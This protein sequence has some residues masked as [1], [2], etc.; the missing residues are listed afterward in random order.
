MG[1]GLVIAIVV[2]VGLIAIVVGFIVGQRNGTAKGE[3]L[4]RETL[5]EEQ[6][7]EGQSTLV[8]ARDE[9]P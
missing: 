9:S 1:T 4:G 6:K 8:E 5:L 3:T 7:I 2:V